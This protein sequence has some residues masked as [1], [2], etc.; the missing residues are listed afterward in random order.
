MKTII[1]KIKV[2]VPLNGTKFRMISWNI[3]KIVKSIKISIVLLIL[4][5]NNWL[6]NL[7]QIKGNG[8]RIKIKIL[9]KI[10]KYQKFFKNWLIKLFH[11]NKNLKRVMYLFIWL[12][13]KIMACKK[14]ETTWYKCDQTSRKSLLA[15]FILYF[16]SKVAFVCALK[17]C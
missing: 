3:K 10:I 5:T 6:S 11:L 9:K 12:Y 7:S 14:K 13:S 1:K 15:Y 4:H 8:F 16:N 2:L 17:I